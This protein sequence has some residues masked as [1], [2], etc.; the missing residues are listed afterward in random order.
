MIKLIAKKVII[1]VLEIESRL[2]LARQKP[3]IIAV[4]GSVGKTSAKDAI[5]SAL[6]TFVSVRKSEK[7]FNGEIGVPLTILGLPNAWNNPIKWAQNIGKGF[8]E[9]ISSRKDYPKYLVLEIG[10]DRPGDIAKVV[11]WLR[12]DIAVLTRLPEVPVHVEFFKNPH[13]IN[14]EDK[15]IL[16]SLKS[17]GL[18]IL[19]ADDEII[20]AGRDNLKQRITT[21]GCDDSKTDTDVKATHIEIAY[22]D[23]GEPIGTQF[24]VHIDGSV[25]PMQFNGALGRHHVYPFIVALAVAR[26]LKL[27]PIEVAE[28]M[29]KHKPPKGRMNIVQGMNKSTI[30][31][32]TYN[33]SPVALEEALKTLGEIKTSGKKIAVIGDMLELGKFTEGEHE[34]VGR[35]AGNVVD[36]LVLLG[37][38]TDAFGAGAHS[39]GLH[40]SKIHPMKSKEEA[41]RYLTKKIGKGDVIL[42]K[43]SQGMRLEKLV[44]GIMLHPEEAE[45]LLVRQEKEW[46]NI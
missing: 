3:K 41:L 8:L 43:G 32:D 44:K 7:S 6:H 20:L 29:V 4:A 10:S 30:I 33:S 12:S 15:K 1:K 17:D 24:K 38:R 42:I 34:R 35:I 31:D 45:N 39:A 21:F 5:W 16:K 27:N 2:V 9:V 22:S 28:A 13:E 25:I 23:H 26:E 40:H 14:Q 11:R 46:E 18:A 37:I 36:N 19:N